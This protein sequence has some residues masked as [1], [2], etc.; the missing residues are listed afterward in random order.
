MTFQYFALGKPGNIEEVVYAT[1]P[2]GKG[3]DVIP[4]LNVYVYRDGKRK[5]EYSIKLK[6]GGGSYLNSLTLNS[7]DLG[8]LEAIDDS[9]AI[10]EVLE[11]SLKIEGR[12]KKDNV[13]V[14][15]NGKKSRKLIKR[16]E[17]YY[18]SRKESKRGDYT[19][20]LMIETRDVK[21]GLVDLAKKEYLNYDYRVRHDL[22]RDAA[23]DF[24]SY[25]RGISHRT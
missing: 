8:G 13:N 3:V 10:I 5:I 6:I 21:R 14:T 24:Y 22:F 9:D 18:H 7:E 17:K 23:A 2:D 15:I 12:L 16:L 19:K 1:M 4:T 25:L 20:P 11:K